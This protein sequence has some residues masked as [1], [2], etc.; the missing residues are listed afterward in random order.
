L[1]IAVILHAPAEI[2]ESLHSK[3]FFHNRATKENPASPTPPRPC[4][5][6]RGLSFVK[7]KLN[8]SRS[9]PAVA[10]DVKKFDVNRAG[11]SLDF[12]EFFFSVSL[13]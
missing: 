5:A 4:H 12:V 11:K 9:I 6:E 10:S 1:V 3:S 13:W 2:V 7:A 8:R